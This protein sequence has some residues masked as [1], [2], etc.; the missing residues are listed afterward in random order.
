MTRIARWAVGITVI[1]MTAMHGLAQQTDTV[2][3][4]LD[5][6]YQ[7]AFPTNWQV[8]PEQPGVLYASTDRLAMVVFSPTVMDDLIAPGSSLT[9]A[10]IDTFQF[11]SGDPI[12]SEQVQTG[13][14]SGRDY[15]VAETR[16]VLR[17]T[18]YSGRYFVIRMS[19]GA[20]G[21]VNLLIITGEADDYT[22]E[23]ESIIS[24]FDVIERAAVD[25]PSQSP[26]SPTASP[27]PAPTEA[28]PSSTPSPTVAAGQIVPVSGSVTLS[29]MP[30][31][32]EAT[33]SAGF[34]P[35]E[36]VLT[37]TQIE[38][39]LVAPGNGDTLHLTF[40]TAGSGDA[41]SASRLERTPDTNNYTGTIRFGGWSVGVRLML[42]AAERFEGGP[43]SPFV[44]ENL[45]GFTGTL[46]C[47]DAARITI[48][49]TTVS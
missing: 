31:D 4:P 41:S 47:V 12:T 18:P 26:E 32:A 7:L 16:P 37:V 20:F 22:A 30:S 29:I 46:L 48:R 2:T 10:L 36:Q 24:T 17:D 38:G 1:L 27:E 11:V 3:Y 45:D 13:Q 40:S 8:S 43:T 39:V 44:I 21:A 5:D 14:V 25:A 49:V 9:D 35:L 34:A 6:E 33:C 23:I 19:D 28:E 15:V 42:V